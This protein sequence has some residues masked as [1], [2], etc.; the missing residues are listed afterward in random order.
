M[1]YIL[2]ILSL[3]TIQ[4]FCQNNQKLQITPLTKDLYVFTTYQ[5][6]FPANGMYLVTEQGA[7]MIDTPWDTTQFQPLLDS[8]RVKHHKGVAVCIATHSHDDRTAGLTFYAKKGAKTYTTKQTDDISKKKNG[9][10]ANFVISNDTTFVVGRHVFQTF[11]PGEGHTSD[12][13]VVW[14]GKQKVLYGGCLIKSV[15]ATDLGYIAEANLTAWPTTIKNLQERFSKA[16]YVIPGH[17][18]WKDAKS[19]EHT[20][21]L[22]AQKK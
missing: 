15:E 9:V 13:I 22:L 19:L 8:I 7:V 4:G 20:L 21:G 16:K 12:N 10:R 17:Q 14:F 2:I 6:S 11:H 1:K 18:N 3:F 5:N